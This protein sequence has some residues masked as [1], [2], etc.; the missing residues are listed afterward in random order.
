MELFG[1][2]RH[3]RGVTADVGGCNICLWSYHGL[4]NERVPDVFEVFNYT[5]VS[6][7]PS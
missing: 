7:R 1:E 3:D 5:Y 2:I 6:E 4:C